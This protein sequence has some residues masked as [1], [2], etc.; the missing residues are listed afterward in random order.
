[1][2][3]KFTAVLVLVG[4]LLLCQIVFAETPTPPQDI[5]DLVS[6]SYIFR[7]QPDTPEDQISVMAHQLSASYGGKLRH[8]YKTV[9]KGFS[10]TIS[11]ANAS[12]MLS[13]NPS[14]L[15]YSGNAALTAN[16]PHEGDAGNAG[17]VPRPQ[18]PDPNWGIYRIG[19]HGNGAGKHAW[20]FDSGIDLDNPDL[21]VSKSTGI[22][23]IDFAKDQINDTIG[24]G[25]SISGIIAGLGIET[26]VVG[27]ASG[28]TVHPVRVLH[29]NL[30]GSIDD[31]ICGLEYVAEHFSE[32]DSNPMHH[33]INFSIY[34][35]VGKYENEFQVMEDMFESVA[36][37]G[38]RIAVCA[39][40]EDEDASLYS[41][42]RIGAAVAGI[43]TV[44]YTDHNDILSW[45]ANYGNVIDWAAPGV[46]ITS[47][48]VGGGV[49]TWSGCSYATPHVA[50]ILLLGNDPVI[51]GYVTGKDGYS[52]PIATINGMPLPY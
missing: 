28:A 50:G 49:S 17:K 26:D 42:A 20:I 38:I 45:K 37:M 36:N 30:W 34:G 39:G 18:T 10:A 14:I 44:T 19:G 15:S 12:L 27:V 24:H 35:E 22:N 46:N 13:Q 4:G 29:N 23:C 32:V 6:T 31:F 5:K 51:D 2:T 33:V 52:I 43:Y 25:T 16:A 3:S 7:L 8:I 9:F 41:P 48:K 47:L 40:N 1:M 11:A 21:I